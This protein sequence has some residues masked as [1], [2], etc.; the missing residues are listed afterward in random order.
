M[1]CK[2]LVDHRLN[3]ARTIAMKHRQ[4]DAVKLARAELFNGKGRNSGRLEVAGVAPADACNGR[5]TA[6]SE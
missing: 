4:L 5:F 1:F 2:C 3:A 6:A